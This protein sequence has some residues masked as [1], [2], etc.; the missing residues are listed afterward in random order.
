MECAKTSRIPNIT[1]AWKQQLVDRD[2]ERPAGILSEPREEEIRKQPSH[3]PTV[4]LEHREDGS[5][6]T[7][8]QQKGAG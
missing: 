4:E 5:E 6:A 7:G 1:I 2:A 8:R 3:S